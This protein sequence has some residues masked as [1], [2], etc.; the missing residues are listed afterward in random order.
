MKWN[1]EMLTV[2]FAYTNANQHDFFS[3]VLIRIHDRVRKWE[4]LGKMRSLVKQ[5]EIK[6]GLD[7]SYQEL[8]TCSMRFNVRH[9]FLLSL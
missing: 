5:T 8:R 2:V 6:L 7:Q 1:G 3:S 4:E 9:P